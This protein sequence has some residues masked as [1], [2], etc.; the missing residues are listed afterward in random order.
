MNLTVRLYWQHD[1][2]LICLHV[3]PDFPSFG[4][5]C[6]KALCAYVRGTEF[7]IPVPDEFHWNKYVDS[8]TCV[9]HLD[10]EKDKDVIQFME[11]IKY[12]FRCNFL[13]QIVRGYMDFCFVTPYRKE[14]SVNVK[15]RVHRNKKNAADSSAILEEPPVSEK[16][17]KNSVPKAAI[18]KEPVN[19]VSNTAKPK[20]TK[21][22]DPKKPVQK[23]T[24]PKAQ[25]PETQVPETSV[26]KT[27]IPKKSIP[28][29]PAPE[30]PEYDISEYLVDEEEEDDISQ[31]LVEDEDEIEE[32]DISPAEEDSSFNFFGEMA[33]LINQ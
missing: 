8:K 17:P 7:S 1:L 14:N 4:I 28:K 15:S 20:T 16:T 31:Y 5:L 25:V 13:K 29:K 3:S 11:G 6:K 32:K 2:D 9:V 30:E 18:E 10:Q 21:S 26:S 33:K 23:K 24:V 22:T 19:N 12:G 27:A